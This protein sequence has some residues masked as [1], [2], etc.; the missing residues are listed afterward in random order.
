MNIQVQVCGLLIVLM[1]YFFYKSCNTLNL[2]TEKVF[3]QAMCSSI[4][5]LSLDILSVV[6]IMNRNVLPLRL[7]E[8]ICKLYIITLVWVAM[9]AFV[10]VLTDLFNE[11]THMRWAKIIRGIVCAQSVLV[12]ILPIGIFAEGRVVYTYGS[13]VLAVYGSVAVYILA[14][15]VTIGVR[16][17]QLNKRRAI[18]VALWMFVYICAAIIQFL[19][20]E[21]LLV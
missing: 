12:Y 4:L 17:K 8:A 1:L 10:Y 7:V 9:Y 16:F 13:A 20:N 14:T 21:L 2:Y 15:L 19:N 6:F 3:H 11:E 18:A 5:C